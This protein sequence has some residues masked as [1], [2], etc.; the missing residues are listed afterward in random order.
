MNTSSIIYTKE[1]EYNSF[2]KSIK[3]IILIVFLIIFILILIWFYNILKKSIICINQIHL[4]TKQIKRLKKR[5][6]NNSEYL[7]LCHPR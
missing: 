1:I 5:N 2:S 6:G 3:N 4:L 7:S